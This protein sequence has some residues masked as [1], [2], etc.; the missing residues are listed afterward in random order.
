MIRRS[1]R[2][3]LLAFAF[4]ALPAGLVAQQRD[5]RPSPVSARRPAPAKRPPEAQ[6]WL[7][8]LQVLNAKLEAIQ[9]RALQDPQL[10]AAQQSLGGTIK[11]AMSRIDPMLEQNVARGRQLQQQAL[12]ARQKGDQAT[13][14]Q[15]AGEMQAIQQRFFTVQQ[16]VVQEPALAAQLKSFQ[17][18]VQKKMTSLDATTPGMIARFGELQGKLAAT[19]K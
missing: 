16:Q 2:S 9:A 4:V 15:L 8:E 11:A 3:M 14:N 18:R 1:R 7:S 6:A 12:A 13:L 19:M 5:A 17:D 10:M